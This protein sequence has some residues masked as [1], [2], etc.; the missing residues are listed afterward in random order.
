MEAKENTAAPVIK[1]SIGWRMFDFLSK[2][3]TQAVAVV[4]ISLL[5]AQ[6]L[7]GIFEKAWS[8][9]D[10]IA[11]YYGKTVLIRFL[12]FIGFLNWSID[13]FC[14]AYIHRKNAWLWTFIKRP[15]TGLLALLLVWSLTAIVYASDR[16]LAFFGGPFR[17][18]GFLSYLAYAGIFVNASLIRGEKE[19]KIVFAV[20]TVVSTLLAALTLIRET[21]GSS[22]FLVRGIQFMSYSS[23]FVNPNH[24][25][26]YLCVSMAVIA[27]L[28][29]MSK[30]L[31]GKIVCGLCFTL[32]AAVL[33]LNGS[34]GPYIAAALGLLLLFAFYL[35]RG[36][37]KN[38][39]PALIP[40][41]IL[42]GLSLVLKE[43]Q[44]LKDLSSFIKQTSEV[45]EIAIPGEAISSE[46][47]S[48]IDH[49]GS[50]RGRLWKQTIEVIKGNPVIGVGTD[51]IHLYIGNALPHS[52]FLQIAANMGIPALVVYMAALISCFVYVIKNLKKFSDGALFAGIAMFVYCV[53]GFVGITI[54]VTT[55][56]LF[57]FWGMLTGWVRH[58][59]YSTMS[60]RMLAELNRKREELEAAAAE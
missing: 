30:K 56:Q 3:N 44:M 12:G 36:G 28:F 6:V 26:Y 52:E 34:L 42:V 14:K 41:I 46:Q 18:E 37:F 53:S 40:I 1:K 54:P 59:D 33:L 60:E 55:Y 51:N 38:A 5:S 35:I 50:T 19:R 16:D 39:W 22:V 29:M 15:W 48:L 58:R 32:N 43:R 57:L 45:I 47:E 21:I 27:G 20:T 24:Y 9:E 25:G 23:T 31:W 17:Y 13:F 4:V 8:S 7:F 49:Y 2:I 10:L 11:L